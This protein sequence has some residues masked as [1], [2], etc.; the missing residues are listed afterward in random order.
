MECSRE[1]IKLSYQYEIL[2]AMAPIIY[3]LV[4]RIRAALFSSPIYI[5]FFAMS[6]VAG[7]WGNNVY[8]RVE[9]MRRLLALDNSPLALAAYTLM[10]SDK[11]SEKSMKKFEK[12]YKLSTFE[13]RYENFSIGQAVELRVIGNWDPEIQGFTPAYKKILQIR[14]KMTVEDIEKLRK[15]F[16]YRDPYFVDPNEHLYLDL[17]EESA[18]LNEELNQITSPTG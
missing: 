14:D 12:R 10:K 1:I 8:S 15:N 2:G 9:C 16:E 17:D 7:G 3:F 6:S 11:F 18:R 4:P 5:A 13:E